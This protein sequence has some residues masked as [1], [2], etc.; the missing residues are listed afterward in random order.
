[1]GKKILFAF[2]AIG[3]VA[4]IAT[5]CNNEKKVVDLH[6][7]AVVDNT[8]RKNLPMEEFYKEN[9]EGKKAFVE[10]YR[11]QLT[12]NVYD[13]SYVKEPQ[14]I[15]FLI[16]SGTAMDLQGNDKKL[17]NASFEDEILVVTSSFSGPDT[18]FVFNGATC[19]ANLTKKTE[20]GNG[21][22]WRFEIKNNQGLKDYLNLIEKWDSLGIESTYS[23]PGLKK[24]DKFS[25]FL[26][27]NEK[28]LRNGDLIDCFDKRVMDQEAHDVAN[29]KKRQKAKK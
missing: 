24:G 3:T 17:C 7:T 28:F 21:E 25:T 15:T 5:S 12:Y 22:P 4:V 11:M 27:E 6:E 16:A 2:M 23:M 1:M 20:L 18:T 9:L 29:F 26:K 19:S 10:Q 14:D 8:L 13:K